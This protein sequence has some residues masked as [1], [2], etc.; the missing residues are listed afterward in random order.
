MIRKLKKKTVT[1]N[2]VEDKTTKLKKTAK[3]NTRI[4]QGTKNNQKVIK[5]GVPVDHSPKHIKKPLDPT[6]IAGV[7]IGVTKNMGEYESLRVD[8]WL[9]D[10]VSDNETHEEAIKRLYDIA[11]NSVDDILSSLQ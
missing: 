3:A 2:I 5:E 4:T 9:T 11:Y 1:E 8:C 6:K 10:E 7:N